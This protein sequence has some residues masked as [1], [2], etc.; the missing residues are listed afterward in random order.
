MTNKPD[1]DQKKPE[2]M[3][4]MNKNA[5]TNQ[6]EV[7]SKKTNWTDTKTSIDP[8]RSMNDKSGKLAKENEKNRNMPSA[9]GKNDISNK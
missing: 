9:S 4:E 7:G 8:N 6:P 1:Y 3:N 5:R 2:K